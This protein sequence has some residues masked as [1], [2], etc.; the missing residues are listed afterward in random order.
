MK[1]LIIIDCQNDLITGTLACHHATDAVENIIDYLNNHQDVEVFY[2]QDW[3]SPT[4]QSFS[5]NGG[6]WPV[7]CVANTWGS[8]LA[9][10]FSLKL[11]NET[12]M[13]N[14]SNRYL[15]GK[16][17]RIEEYSAFYAEN[18]DG[19]V[20]FQQLDE[21]VMIAGIASEYCVL[22]TI[23][24]LKKKNHEVHVLFEGLGYVDPETH[25]QA[26]ETYQDLGVK[27]L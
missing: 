8:A 1:Q 12:Q 13:P 17:D 6:I 2:S 10:A 9:D 3:H 21:E 16:D 20:L 24:E 7:H 25:D 19:K 26:M 14:E 27:A 4:N 18:K 23:K 5:E 11:K 15:K 22:E